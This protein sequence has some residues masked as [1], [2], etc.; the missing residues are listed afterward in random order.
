MIRY[1]AEVLHM[2]Q[3]SFDV[4]IHIIKDG[5]LEFVPTS[6][7]SFFC[8]ILNGTQVFFQ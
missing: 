2:G 3:G 5:C 4:E 6:L 8:F 7:P 1:F